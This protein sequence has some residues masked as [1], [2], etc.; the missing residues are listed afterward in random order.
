[1][2]LT[3]I[4]DS[5]AAPNS[6]IPIWVGWYIWVNLLLPLLEATDRPWAFDWRHCGVTLSFLCHRAAYVSVLCVKHSASAGERREQH[7]LIPRAGVTTR[8]C[9]VTAVDRNSTRSTRNDT[10][11]FSD[12]SLPP[13]V[14]VHLLMVSW[15]SNDLVS[16]IHK[17]N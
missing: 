13:Q 15:D 1:M 9:C 3:L 12:N 6:L 16:N 17:E 5:G 8:V 4:Q 10:P 7:S 2:W 11:E 14:S